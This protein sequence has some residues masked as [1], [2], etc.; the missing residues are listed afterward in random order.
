MVCGTF[1]VLLSV[2]PCGAMVHPN[3]KAKMDDHGLGQHTVLEAT[4]CKYQV[5]DAEGILAGFSLGF[6]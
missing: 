6:K 4:L 5:Q 1:L 2:G 3:E